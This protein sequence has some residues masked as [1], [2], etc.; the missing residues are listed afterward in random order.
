MGTKTRSFLNGL[1]FCFY[2]INLEI[3]GG[4]TGKMW[5]VLLEVNY[6]GDLKI[7]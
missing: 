6:L 7:I 5:K 2:W 1:V 3:L 4:N